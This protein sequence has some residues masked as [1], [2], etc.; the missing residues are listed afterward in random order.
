MMSWLNQNKS[1][2]LQHAEERDRER[3]EQAEPSASYSLPTGDG[4]EVEEL[5]AEEFMRFFQQQDKA[6]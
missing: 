2:A 1:D 3:A 5:S 4:L 6:A